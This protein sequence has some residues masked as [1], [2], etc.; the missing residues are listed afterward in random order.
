MDASFESGLTT[1]AP[2]TAA[3]SA[4][5]GFSEF[6]RAHS[7]MLYAVCLRITRNHHDAEDASAKGAVFLRIAMFCSTSSGLKSRAKPRACSRL[8]IVFRL[9]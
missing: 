4:A 5:H 8:A 1:I 9:R 2:T 3:L 6:V 7:K